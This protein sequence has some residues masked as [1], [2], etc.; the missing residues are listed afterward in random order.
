MV[1]CRHN[2]VQ[3]AFGDLAALVWSLVMKEPI[4]CDGSADSLITDL[5]ISGVWES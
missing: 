2:E 4:V 3:D 5:C 1:T